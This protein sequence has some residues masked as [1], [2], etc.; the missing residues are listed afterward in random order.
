MYEIMSSSANYTY[1][2]AKNDEV[3]QAYGHRLTCPNCGRPRCF[4][5]Y[6]DAWG[7]PITTEVGK[8]DHINSCGYHYTPAQYF[9]EHR[10]GVQ[11]TEPMH[12]VRPIKPLRSY[13]DDDTLIKSWRGYR[14]NTLV[15]W[16]RSILSEAETQ[17]LCDVYGIGTARNGSAIY[18]QLDERDRCRGG[19][20]M[21]Y[22]PNTGHRVKDGGAGRVGWAHTMLGLDD[23]H[24]EQCLFGLHR[25]KEEPTKPIAIFESEKT[26]LLAEVLL[27]GNGFSCLPMATGGAG[28]L[29]AERMRPLRGRDVIIFPDNGMFADWYDKALAACGSC[30]SVRIS[31]ICEAGNIGYMYDGCDLG[32]YL[33]AHTDDIGKTLIDL[34]IAASLVDVA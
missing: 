10:D 30:R 27:N 5:P 21:L 11:R 2:L 33:A 17:W 19:K 14:R 20:V 31:T 4:V 13:I 32:D 6:V 8:C 29:T 9:R 7:E 28:N 25:L 15:V 24:L 34:H 12:H 16:L 1:H 3:K 26:A 23:Y 22:D 18:W